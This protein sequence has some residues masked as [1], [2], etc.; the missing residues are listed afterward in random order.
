M[1]SW[2]TPIPDYSECPEQ[3]I[4]SPTSLRHRGTPKDTEEYEDMRVEITQIVGDHK[5]G[6]SIYYEGVYAIELIKHNGDIG[7][8]VSKKNEDVQYLKNMLCTFVSGVDIQLKTIDHTGGCNKFED[9]YTAEQRQLE[10]PRPLVQVKTGERTLDFDSAFGLIAEAYIDVDFDIRDV[11]NMASKAAGSSNNEQY[12][13]QPVNL[14]RK[15]KGSTVTAKRLSGRERYFADILPYLRNN[16]QP[17]YLF[18]L[19]QG[20]I[21]PDWS[22]MVDKHGTNIKII[23][24]DETGSLAI[25]DLGIRI[26]SDSER[27][28]IPYEKVTE[29]QVGVYPSIEIYAA[30]EIHKFRLAKSVHSKA[31][32]RE[33]ADFINSVIATKFS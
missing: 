25:T 23:E 14:A 12:S 10:K 7:V 22:Y 3:F 8:A 2:T 15:A 31:E 27:W 29:V 33:C 16:E 19:S 13:K 6:E 5:R 28:V 4:G 24:G 9:I 1:I 21:L 30:N 11:F 26:I 18:A 32:S 20:V 17:H